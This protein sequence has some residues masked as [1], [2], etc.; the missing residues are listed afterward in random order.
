M[1]PVACAPARP[2]ATAARPD[3]T[4]VASPAEPP[5]TITAPEDKPPTTTELVPAR[6]HDSQP[7]VIDE[8]GEAAGPAAG[9][10]AAAA[11]ERQRRERMGTPAVVINDQ[12]LAQHAT[13]RLTVTQA[14]AAVPK[15]GE[16]EKPEEPERGEQY[17]RDRVR[18]LRQQWALAVDAI[19][20]LQERAAGLRTRFYAEADPYVRDGQIKPS[21][22]KALENLQAARERARSLEES[23]AEA[24]EEGRQTGALPGWLRDG[25]DLEPKERPYEEPAKRPPHDDGDLIK[26]PEEL[27]KPPGR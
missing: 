6:V 13:G 12:N 22:D 20:E 11:A 7:V 18:G 16:A 24:L 8:G 5:Q 14:P 17:W 10:V 4:P 1:V 15:K 27:G 3:A 21:W 2:P 19:T 26:E 25:I 9:L 23:L